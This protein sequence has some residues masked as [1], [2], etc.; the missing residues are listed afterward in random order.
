M[1]SD[2]ISGM[3][4]SEL[5]RFKSVVRAA[6]FGIAH[7]IAT[8]FNRLRGGCAERLKMRLADIVRAVPD[9][10]ESMRNH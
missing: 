1:A 9:I 2:T 6:E 8:R 7:R 10:G 5:Y 4:Q 3:A